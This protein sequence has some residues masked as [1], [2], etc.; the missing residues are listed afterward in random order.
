MTL[1]YARKILVRLCLLAAL[2]AL[3]SVWLLESPALRSSSHQPWEVTAIDAVFGHGWEI[4]SWLCILFGAASALAAIRLLATDL[5]AVRATAGR[6]EFSTAFRSTT[7]RW[8]DVGAIGIEVLWLHG[9]E[10]SWLTIEAE[11]RKRR[12]ATRMLDATPAQI[13]TWI[14]EARRLSAQS[15]TGGGGVISGRL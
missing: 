15:P 11:G 9:K 12:V 7:H 8:S 13:R 5:T 4:M 14:D 1:R 10:Q 3:V 6:L 2:F